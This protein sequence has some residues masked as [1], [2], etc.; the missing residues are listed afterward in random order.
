MEFIL[1]FRADSVCTACGT[2]LESGIIVSDVQVLDS[3]LESSNIFIFNAFP[4]QFSHH[5]LP[6]A[7]QFEEN[8]HGGSSA[9]G[10]FVSADR[11]GG[12]GNNFGGNLIDI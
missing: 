8:A 11:K 7:F 4:P 10:T 6:F 2:V 5:C 12:G 3:L 9:I 1:I